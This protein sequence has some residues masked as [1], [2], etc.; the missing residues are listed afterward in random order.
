MRM[1]TC[2][3]VAHSVVRPRAAGESWAIVTPS[4]PWAGRADHKTVINDAGAIYVIGGWSGS[5][6]FYD[7]VWMSTADGLYAPLP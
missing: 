7:D 6:A 4:A 1:G 2:A 3:F 5:D